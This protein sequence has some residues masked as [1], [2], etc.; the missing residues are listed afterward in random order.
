VSR[1]D[2]RPQGSARLRLPVLIASGLGTGFSR[3]APGTVGSLAALPPGILLST[4]PVLLLALILAVCAAGLWAIPRASGGADHGWIVVD[5]VAGQWI[6]LLGVPPLHMVASS[7]TRLHEAAW[8]AGA[9]IL[10][11]LLDITKPGPIAALDRRHDALGV[12]GDDILAGLLG[13][14]LLGLLRLVLGGGS[15]A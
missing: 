8:F 2:S 1:S 4:H 11:R 7:G 5:E 14:M 10:F 6:T 15:P 9:F 13:A 12:M 3:M